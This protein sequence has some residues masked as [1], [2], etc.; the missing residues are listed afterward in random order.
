MR[1]GDSVRVSGFALRAL[2]CHQLLRY[3]TANALRAACT[4]F[5]QLAGYH[6]DV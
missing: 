4:V 6:L 3:G 2:R 1:R 5:G